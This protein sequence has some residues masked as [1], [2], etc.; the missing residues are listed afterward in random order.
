MSVAD[1]LFDGLIADWMM[2]SRISR[3]LTSAKN[4]QTQIEQ[5]LFRLREEMKAAKREEENVRR[6]IDNAVKDA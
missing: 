3:A 1:F 2:K 5:A 4:T 6:M